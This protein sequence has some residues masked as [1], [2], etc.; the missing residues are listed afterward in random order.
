MASKHE[1][2]NREIDLNGYLES[3]KIDPCMGFGGRDPYLYGNS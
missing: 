1:G 3:F 2:K